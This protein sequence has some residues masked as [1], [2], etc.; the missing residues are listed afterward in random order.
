MEFPK[1][2]KKLILKEIIY[3]KILEAL[4]IVHINLNENMLSKAAVDYDIVIEDKVFES[5]IVLN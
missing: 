5:R 3:M 2:R 4:K 1:L